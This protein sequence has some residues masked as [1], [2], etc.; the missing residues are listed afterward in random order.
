MSASSKR[1]RL[2]LDY[3]PAT[4]EVAPR[5]ADIHLHFGQPTSMESA[6]E[7]A[8][9]LNAEKTLFKDPLSGNAWKIR[10]DGTMQFFILATANANPFVAGRL[11]E[12]SVLVD[13]AATDA[14]VFSLVKR[15]L[16]FA[17][18]ESDNVLQLSDYDS[19]VVVMP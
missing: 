9:L 7:G 19:P 12:F 1:I 2:A 4:D 10:S 17:P 18:T 3:A 14:A 8:A 13:G 16:T 5:L 6:T 15:A 11:V